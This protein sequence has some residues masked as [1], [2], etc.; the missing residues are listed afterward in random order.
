MKKLTVST[1]CPTCVN[2]VTGE[3]VVPFDDRFAIYCD[4][5]KE[6][7]EGSLKTATI[8]SSSKDT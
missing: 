1:I 8:I 7:F 5:C 4:T 2:S 6:E 3:V